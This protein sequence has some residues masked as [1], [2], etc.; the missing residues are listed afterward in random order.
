MPAIVFDIDDTLYDLS[1][2]YKHAV[3][4]FFGPDLGI[5][6]DELFVRSR[7]RSDEAYEL[8]LAGKEPVEYMH[9]YRVQK[10]FLDFGVKVSRTD[11]LTFQGVY[12]KH[13]GLIS[14]SPAVRQLLADLA[15]N[16]ISTGVISNGDS[17]HQWAK[18]EALGIPE[19]ISRDCIVISG[20]IGHSKPDVEAFRAM[21]RRLG[22]CP[23]TCWFLGD[24]YECDVLGA[25]G[26]G[27]RCIWFN[28]RNRNLA[29]S[30]LRHTIEVRTEADMIL[31]AREAA[32]LS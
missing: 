29:K 32:G 12:E 9:A 11:A 3:L 14:L 4:E 17:A 26:A 7:V 6:L 2:P 25:L 10:A 28:R 16:G 20:D 30:N 23:D 27:W 18:A 13:Q 8:V 31:R 24:T 5:D 15:Q 1:E 22:V 21:E 19:L